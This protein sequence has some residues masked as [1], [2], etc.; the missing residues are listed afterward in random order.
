MLIQEWGMLRFK[1]LFSTINARRN[2]SVTI[3]ARAGSYLASIPG[4]FDPHVN[5][6]SKMCPA[7]T[8]NLDRNLS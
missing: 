2:I 4:S 8:P 5:W 1:L 7:A 3:H 6:Q